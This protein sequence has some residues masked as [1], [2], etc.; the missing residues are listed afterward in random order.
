VHHAI[1][2]EHDLAR[3]AHFV[4]QASR[5]GGSGPDPESL[6]LFRGEPQASFFVSVFGVIMA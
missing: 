3:Q 5:T 4:S 2:V 1:L 6:A